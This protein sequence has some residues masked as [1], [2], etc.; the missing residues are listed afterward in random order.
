[1]ALPYKRLYE[2][3]LWGASC[4]ILIGLVSL[5]GYLWDVGEII[6]DRWLPPVAV[7]SASINLS[8]AP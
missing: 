1:V 3:A 5:L 8:S 2:L 4:G 7:N 6:T